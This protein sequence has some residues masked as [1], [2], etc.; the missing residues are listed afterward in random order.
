MRIGATPFSTVSILGTR[1][2]VNLNRRVLLPSSVLNAELC[3]RWLE[4]EH[5]TTVEANNWSKGWSN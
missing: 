2:R 1:Y 4:K 5:G 3:E